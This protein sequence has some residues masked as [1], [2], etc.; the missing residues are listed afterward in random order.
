MS[1]YKEIIFLSALMSCTQVSD[2]MPSGDSPSQLEVESPINVGKLSINNERLLLIKRLSSTIN[3]EK[4]TYKIIKTLE[5]G[6]KGSDNTKILLEALERSSCA[7][8]F[9]C[10]HSQSKQRSRYYEE[11]FLE[12]MFF[13]NRL[14]DSDYKKAFSN[15]VLLKENGKEVHINDKI[16]IS[17]EKG[18]RFYSKYSPKKLLVHK[19]LG[20]RNGVSI[21][22]KFDHDVGNQLFRDKIQKFTLEEALYSEKDLTVYFKFINKLNGDCLI[23]RNV[24]L[25]SD[26]GKNILEAIGKKYNKNH[27]LPFSF[28]NQPSLSNLK[29]NL[30]YA[31]TFAEI[32]VFAGLV[33]GGSVLL[34]TELSSDE[35]EKLGIDEYLGDEIY[36][37]P[38][39]N[40]ENWSKI[41][42]QSFDKIE[43]Y[44]SDNFLEHN[45]FLMSEDR[46]NLNNLPSHRTIIDFMD[47]M[48][49]DLGFQDNFF[50]YS[51]N[52]SVAL[53]SFGDN[54]E[55]TVL[56][57][58]LLKEGEEDLQELK[59]LLKA[60]ELEN[61]FRSINKAADFSNTV[62]ESLQENLEPIPKS[63]NIQFFD[64]Y[65]RLNTENIKTLLQAD[66]ESNNYQHFSQ[67][68]SKHIMQE[69]AKNSGMPS[70]SF[71]NIGTDYRVVSDIDWTNKQVTYS[72]EFKVGENEYITSPELEFQ[73]DLD[74]KPGALYSG[75]FSEHSTWTAIP[76][77]KFTQLKNNLGN[78]FAT[79]RQGFIDE[80]S[81]GFTI[82]HQKLIELMNQV[83]TSLGESP[84]YF[85]LSE[86]YS[87]ILE[88]YN[89]DQTKILSLN[90][91]KDGDTDLTKFKFLIKSP[92]MSNDYSSITKPAEFSD[93][94]PEMDQVNL[95]TLTNSDNSEL[96]LKYFESNKAAIET[97]LKADLAENNYRHFSQGIS[98]HIMQEL[99]KNLGM[100]SGSFDNLGR[101]YRVVSSIDWST[102]QAA[103]SL[104][105]KVGDS[106]FIRTENIQIALDLDD[107]PGALY[108]GG[109]SGHSTW[110]AIPTDKFI[111]LKNQLE[112][113]LDNMIASIT[114]GYESSGTI[115]HQGIV[116]LMDEIEE[117]LELNSDYFK[118]SEN[119]SA[120]LE[121]YNT[122]QTKILSLNFVKDGESEL[123]KFKFLIK[124]PSLSDSYTNIPKSPVFSVALTDI[125]QG[126]LVTLNNRENSELFLKY[127]ESNRV[128]IQSL[129][130]R[131]LASNNYR[132]FSQGMSKYLMQEI[133]K[134]AGLPENSFQNLGTD[135]RVITNFNWEDNQKVTYVL[136]FKVG[137]NEFITTRS[138]ELDL[139][140]NYHTGNLVQVPIG[141][142]NSELD[143][144]YDTKVVPTY[145]YIQNNYEEL[146][147]LLATDIGDDGQLDQATVLGIM[148]RIED[149][150]DL[151]THHF[152][153]GKDYT[154]IINTQGV[155]N[156]QIKILTIH[157]DPQGQDSYNFNIYISGPSLSTDYGAI[158]QPQGFTDEAIIKETTVGSVETVK[159]LPREDE[160]T[161]KTIT[162][163]QKL[164]LKE[165][166]KGNIEQ[167]KTLI[168]ADLV[169]N[170]YTHVSKGLY[171]H[172]MKE[173]A[174]VNGL[175][176]GIFATAQQDFHVLERIT[177]D[178]NELRIWIKFIEAN[179]GTGAGNSNVIPVDIGQIYIEDM[180]PAKVVLSSLSLQPFDENA[181]N[182]L[183]DVATGIADS[184]LQG[185]E[186][187]IRDNRSD[188]LGKLSADY[189]ALNGHGVFDSEIS[190]EYR[191][192]LMNNI[193]RTLGI[194]R[195]ELV[196]VNGKYEMAIKN[197]KFVFGT[198]YHAGFTA[199]KTYTIT[200]K[201]NNEIKR[202]E[203]DFSNVVY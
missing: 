166:F 125:D 6:R 170:N 35:I 37:S 171:E 179:D 64:Q 94:L 76:S 38:L 190:Q 104:E 9:F 160:L 88:S 56:V 131:D 77:D 153:Y 186:G 118:L 2:K 183:S 165:Y 80:L 113:E 176:D 168:R 129:L 23:L 15:I 155:G 146:S 119:Y 3:N 121:T 42:S 162:D 169:A 70:G 105:F 187:F 145:D 159:R 18:K 196:S 79:N 5:K 138:V 44:I 22:F 177:S 195:Y 110:T 7:W 61:N 122:D 97:L 99:A 199:E 30:Y 47:K 192:L 25:E 50:S 63:E 180:N 147:R 13:Y 202:Y 175:P 17:P 173:I 45:G 148:D 90:F 137:D 66:L 100:P 133:A 54:D 149:N 140:L 85:K 95:V 48:E 108:A 197:P 60:P 123:T 134:N 154:A 73:L 185:L 144:E 127:F 198:T 69:L 111:G 126:D 89:N 86:N 201:V 91:V 67:G 24:T 52:Y 98:K 34:G 151:V 115:S 40:M 14:P 157:I 203:F 102:K 51:R 194:D 106:D 53:E 139:N 109:F 101:D 71:D 41:P 124:S 81:N 164:F 136:Q 184:K 189:R 96:F 181:I 10:F 191:T 4:S 143:L 87:A 11:E 200:F 75:G 43:D 103:Y 84:D 128:T 20:V 16:F 114:N 107:K 193:G 12:N 58:N 83:E 116:E 46:Y 19:H 57:I 49:R 72:L 130:E 26:N 92:A 93:A 21:N 142:L 62:T 59:M 156:N 117:V 27:T 161:I 167:I 33:I 82:S 28:F 158:P 65:F 132:H 112:N 120:V 182:S 178:K 29:K 39:D 1:N 55:S 31:G 32:G 8:E 174:R 188:I 78:I 172:I 36:P 152:E 141:N 163:N 135:F 74:Y 68:I 150:L